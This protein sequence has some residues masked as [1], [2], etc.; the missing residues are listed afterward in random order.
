MQKHLFSLL[1]LILAVVLMIYTAID[2]FMMDAT[3]NYW[4][5]FIAVVVF[6]LGLAARSK[7]SK[8]NKK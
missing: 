2:Y 3:F 6:F 8:N 7:S 5:F 4:L 1:L